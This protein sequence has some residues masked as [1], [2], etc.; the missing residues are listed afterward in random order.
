MKKLI[1]FSFFLLSLS[2]YSQ[3]IKND[4]LEYEIKIIDPTFNMWL[5]GNARPVGFYSIDY[6]ESYNRYYVTEWN[7]RYMTGRNRD[8]YQFYI[9]Y[10]P[11]VKYGY[12]VNY[13]LFNYFQYFRIKTGERIGIRVR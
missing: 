12:D 11:K 6:L 3:E 8:L 1:L 9:D 13:L 10:D 5:V 2:S 7:Q 4:T